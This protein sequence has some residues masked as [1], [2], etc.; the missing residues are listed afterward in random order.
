MQIRF[1]SRHP[2]ADALAPLAERRLRFVMRRLRWL[3]PRAEVRLSDVDGPRRGVDKRCQVELDSPRLG[4]V[5]VTAIARDWRVAL[6]EA[7]R[8]A[9]HAL[10][11]RW[12]RRRSGEVRQ[13][14]LGGALPAV[15]TTA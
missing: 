3:V 6:D 7:L 10:L 5:V 13:A 15:P 14:R 8:R 11:R 9:S 12:R 4:P 2:D 1:E